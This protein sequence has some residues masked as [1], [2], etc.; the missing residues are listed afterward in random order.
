VA[1]ELKALGLHSVGLAE[2]GRLKDFVAAIVECSFTPRQA[3]FLGLVQEH[4]GACLPRQYRAYAG[5]ARGRQTIGFFQKLIA[6]GLATMDLGAPAHAG[7]IYHAICIASGH[8][9]PVA[10]GLTP[11]TATAGGSGLTVTGTGFVSASQVQWNG[12]P[13][14]TTYVSASQVQAAIEASDVATAGANTVTVVNPSPGG[15]T[16]A[17]LTLQ[18]TPAGQTCHPPVAVV[19]APNAGSPSLVGMWQST[20]VTVQVG[21]VVTVTAAGTWINGGVTTTGAGDPN[22]TLEGTNCPMAGQ[23]SMA[24]IGRIGTT[25]ASFL[26]G[27]SGQFTATTAGVLYLAPNDTWYTLWDNSGSLSV[28]ICVAGASPEPASEAAM[29]KGA[30]GDGRQTPSGSPSGVPALWA[31]LVALAA[32]VTGRRRFAGRRWF[33]AS[34]R[35]ATPLVARVRAWPL[36]LGVVLAMVLLTPTPAIA[37]ADPVEYY[38]LDALGSVRAVTNSSGQLIRLH[39]FK[40]FGEEITP[41]STADRKLFTGQDRDQSTGLDYFGARYYR[42]D[43][44]RFTTVDP[45]HVNGDTFDTQSWSPYA[46]VRNNPLRFT[47][48][49][50]THYLVSV[51]GG[52]EFWVYTDIFYALSLYAY[53]YRLTG[54]SDQGGIEDSSGRELGTYQHYGLYEFTVWRAGHL[55]QPVVDLAEAALGAVT[56]AASFWTPTAVAAAGFGCVV[57]GE[58]GIGMLAA[59]LPLPGWRQLKPFRGKT[60]TNGLSGRARRFFEWDH[61]HHDMEVYDALGRH[62]GS[63]DPNTGVMTKPPKPGRKIG[64]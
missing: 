25:G 15:G 17:E 61:T 31:T 38:H 53:P 62:L 37:Q 51:M 57:E 8:P 63:A 48:P 14:S 46:S 22:V 23:R 26:V 16:S 52:S 35:W 13:R 50:G 32:V 3:R 60:K 28:T 19:A 21:D 36:W 56:I 44:G 34:T 11:A 54:N 2:S 4:S 49:S 59:A 40:P 10:T 30:G 42:T 5:V 29:L 9:V 24:L 1:E 18:V 12:S 33:S 6:G 45:G 55:A 58:C 43:L 64:K 47:D 20:G 27:A 41:P 39:D 7:R